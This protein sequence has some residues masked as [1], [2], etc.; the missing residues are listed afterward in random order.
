MK[1]KLFTLCKNNNIILSDKQLD[2][3]EMFYDYLLKMNQVMN[4]TS[5]TDENE[6]IIKHFF[7]SISLV[8]YFEIPDSSRVIDVGTGAGFPGI[9]LAIL[10]PNVKFVLMDSL[11]KRI[12]FLKNVVE[13]CKLDNVECIHSRA[14]ILAKNLN[15]RECYD[16]CVSRAVANLSVLLEYC[17]PFIK[18]GG[19]F[20]SYKSVSS[21]DELAASINAQNKLCCKFK[22]NISFNLPDTDNQRNFLIFEK[23]DHT[24][25]KYPRNN[26]VPR[27]TP[28]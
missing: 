20:V 6:V 28:L 10:N 19:S 1:T 8:N 3:F 14:E 26:G 9:P 7:D 5:I 18:K 27:K 4:L 21:D 23:F 17:I 16:I 22:K 25:S 13:I 15:H 11:N 24:A 2:Q 12:E